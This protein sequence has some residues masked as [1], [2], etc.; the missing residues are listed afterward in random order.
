MNA[1][2]LDVGNT[3]LK[4]ATS[5][6]GELGRSRSILRA[7]LDERGLA[8]LTAKLPRR[9]DTILVSNVAGPSFGMRL[10]GVL[11]IHCDCDVHFVS[12]AKNAFGV[13]N[14]YRQPRRMGVDRWV[15]MIG[16]WAELGRCCL[17]VDAGTAVTLDVL[18]DGGNHLGGQ[19]LPG[20]QLMAGT[21]A[22]ETSDIGAVAGSRKRVASGMEIF[23][24]STA[25]AVR[26]GAG[27]AVTGAVERAITTLRSNAYDPVVV[28]TG[29]DAS[30]MLDAF[31]EEPLLR[32]DLVLQGLKHILENRQ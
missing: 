5:R 25:E 18:D 23:G 32:P 10:S 13:T 4:W 27:N 24:R 16:A 19:I 2:L 15:A 11:G 22:G 12:T 17:I 14:G 6:H 31:A 7:R 21:L 20:M 3:R 9:V 30:R 1:L 8:A 26:N 28:L 29:G